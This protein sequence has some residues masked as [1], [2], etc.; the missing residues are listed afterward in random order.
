MR[1]KE[2][3]GKDC[4]VWKVT[5]PPPGRLPLQS[6]QPGAYGTVNTSVLWHCSVLTGWDALSLSVVSMQLCK[7]QSMT[8]HTLSGGAATH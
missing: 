5:N 4:V 1:K 6:M 8:P 2:K 3:K 7:V